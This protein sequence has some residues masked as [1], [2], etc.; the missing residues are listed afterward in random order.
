[1]KGTDTKGALVQIRKGDR[2]SFVHPEQKKEIEGIV[3]GRARDGRIKVTAITRFGG[4]KETLD[5]NGKFEG[6]TYDFEET[7]F[8]IPKHFDLK[9]VHQRKVNG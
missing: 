1:M 6:A 4:R 7:I 2:V 8:T 3:S 9:V 5:A